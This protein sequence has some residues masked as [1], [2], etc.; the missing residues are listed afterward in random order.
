MELWVSHNR[1][2][3]ELAI[4]PQQERQQVSGRHFNPICRECIL[5]FRV[6][7]FSRRKDEKLNFYFVTQQFYIVDSSEDQVMLCIYHNDTTASLYTS[8]YRGVRYTLSLQNVAF[9]DI[10]QFLR[11]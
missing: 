5:C 1:S 7:D 11:T 9:Y 8:S 10:A 2:A 3:F 6:D 4:F